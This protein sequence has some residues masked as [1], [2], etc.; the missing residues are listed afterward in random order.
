MDI[1]ETRVSPVHLFKNFELTE[2]KVNYLIV[3]YKE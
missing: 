2:E 1:K 3:F